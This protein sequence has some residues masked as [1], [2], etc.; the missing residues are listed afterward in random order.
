MDSQRKTIDGRTRNQWNENAK[1]ADGEHESGDLK[2]RNQWTT[3]AKALAVEDE[4]GGAPRVFSCF[5]F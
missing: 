2:T 3:K 5:S 4:S 1:L